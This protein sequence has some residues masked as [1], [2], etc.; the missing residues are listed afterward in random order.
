MMLTFKCHAGQRLRHRRKVIIP[1]SSIIIVFELPVGVRNSLDSFDPPTTFF[2]K[3]TP[4]TTLFHDS[5]QSPTN[6]SNA[7]IRT[8]RL[9]AEHSQQLPEYSEFNLCCNKSNHKMFS[10]SG[11][12]QRRTCDHK[13]VSFLRV[14]GLQQKTLAF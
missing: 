3:I 9:G 7:H 11:V 6:A 12:S 4:T 1:A 10:V 8:V 14:H 2:Q 13:I 5:C